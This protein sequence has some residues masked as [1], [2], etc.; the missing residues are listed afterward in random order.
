MM[1]K[2]SF[3]LVLISAII[4]CSCAAAARISEADA[5][6]AVYHALGA[7]MAE[8]K[9]M[10]CEFREDIVLEDAAYYQIAVREKESQKL[11]GVFAVHQK[12]GS[13]LRYDSGTEEWMAI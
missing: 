4:L 9:E 11:A 3:L 2:L 6:S 13:L 1:R 7:D 12:D 8:I 5:K 10:A